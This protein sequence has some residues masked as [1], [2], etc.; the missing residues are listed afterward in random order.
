MRTLLTLLILLALPGAAA[1]SAVYRWIDDQ[2][3]PHFSD[4]LPDEPGVVATQQ[5]FDTPP[6][7]APER[8]PI[9]PDE[10][11]GQPP[12]PATAPAPEP[13]PAYERLT[14]VSPG[15]GTVVT[16]FGETI[17]IILDVEPGLAADHVLRLYLDGVRRI[18][19]IAPSIPLS[20]VAAGEHTLFA[21][22]V[23]T[24][25]RPLARS[26]THRFTVRAADDET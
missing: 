22:I 18:T 21:E 10:E 9:A 19:E 23:D 6:A 4:R 11:P 14:L 15:D 3:V 25:G 12:E 24:A 2:G 13:A 8:D 26:E 7:R 20:G 16:A 17:D 5:N 1:A